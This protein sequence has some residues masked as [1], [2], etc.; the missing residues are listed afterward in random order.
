MA[1]KGIHLAYP[2]IPHIHIIVLEYLMYGCMYVTYNKI[3][4]GVNSKMWKLL[5]DLG[6]IKT[7]HYIT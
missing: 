3:L 5:K 7:I 4:Y 2:H 6:T 1:F